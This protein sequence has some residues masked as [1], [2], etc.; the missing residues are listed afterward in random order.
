[1]FDS[2]ANSLLGP[3]FN[4]SS[5]LVGSLIPLISTI[6]ANNGLPPNYIT[7]GLSLASLT[8]LIYLDFNSRKSI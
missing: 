5:G 3:T 7:I 2:K 8:S 4:L 6:G 1:M